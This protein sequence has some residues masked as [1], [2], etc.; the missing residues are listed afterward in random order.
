MA[1]NK[2]NKSEKAAKRVEKKKPAAEGELNE[3]EL[4]EVNGGMLLPAVQKVREAAA[5]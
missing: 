5:R 2:K 3:Q 4:S 1:E